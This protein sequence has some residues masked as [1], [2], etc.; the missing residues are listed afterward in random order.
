MKMM[1]AG[2]CRPLLVAAVLAL[3]GLVA[4]HTAPCAA[5]YAEDAGVYDWVQQHIGH[6]LLAAEGSAGELVVATREGVIARIDPDSSAI[7]WRV[8]L[9]ETDVVDELI[10][11]VFGGQSTVI[12]VCG[13]AKRVVGLTM[14]HGVS[15][16]DASPGSIPLRDLPSSQVPATPP[17]HASLLDRTAGVDTCLLRS[18]SGPLVVTLHSSRVAFTNGLTG[19]IDWSIDLADTYSVLSLSCS[20]KGRVRAAARTAGSNA[21]DGGDGDDGDDVVVLELDPQ[22]KQMKE[23]KTA[24]SGDVCT[25]TDAA[26]VCASTATAAATDIA[27]AQFSAPTKVHRLSVPIKSPVTLNAL[28]EGALVVVTGADGESAIVTVDGAKSSVEQASGRVHLQR[29]P[30]KTVVATTT[31]MNN[32]AALTLIFCVYLPGRERS[33]EA[34]SSARQCWSL[35]PSYYLDTS[36]TYGVSTILNVANSGADV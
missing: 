19:N 20:P 29:T 15:V 8:T 35:P 6:V 16:L 14:R 22:T 33:A 18:S 10:V 3:V 36:G 32:R 26:V 5:L 34:L 21:S 13:G 11:S 31:A 23:A 1:M 30:R 7:L 17:Q 27:I 9:R 24:I 2:S 12:A 25:T 28:S 4:L